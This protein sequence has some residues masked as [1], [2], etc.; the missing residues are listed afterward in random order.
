MNALQAMSARA[1]EYA[2]MV[3]AYAKMRA[4]HPE[5]PAWLVHAYLQDGGDYRNFAEFVCARTVGHRWAYTG[6]A[7]GGDDE[8]YDGEGRCY[9]A[10]CGADGD[11]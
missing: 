2:A 1:A 3:G 8:S 11:A 5:A 6:S 7:Y 9:C 4:E 10:H